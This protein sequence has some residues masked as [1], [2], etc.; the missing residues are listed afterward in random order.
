MWA[1]LQKSGPNGWARIRCGRWREGSRKN[2]FST[3]TRTA[4]RGREG[5]QRT[6]GREP[7]GTTKWW[8]KRGWVRGVTASAT[9]EIRRRRTSRA[10]SR[11]RWR[12]SVGSTA[13]WCTGTNRCKISTWR[14]ERFP[15]GAAVELRWLAIWLSCII[16]IVIISIWW[17]ELHKVSMSMRI[18][19]RLPDPRI[20]IITVISSS[21]RNDSI[22]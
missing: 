6:T 2:V 20:I 13:P 19:I 8:R 10:S 9:G 12:R 15:Q 5:V 7:G 16:H 11:R 14:H 17:A 1:A 21:S 4:K 18:C 3:V 22:M